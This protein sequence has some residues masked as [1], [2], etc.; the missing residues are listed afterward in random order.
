VA[1]SCI[2]K[3]VAA[4]WHVLA[5]KPVVEKPA[6]D[7]YVPKVDF[8]PLDVARAILQTLTNLPSAR[9]WLLRAASVR[10]A[11][12]EDVPKEDLD[13]YLNQLSAAESSIEELCSNFAVVDKQFEACLFLEL[14]TC[15]HRLGY[16]A[17]A[18]ELLKRARESIGLNFWLDG[19]MGKR[20]KFQIDPK[21]QLVLNVDGGIKEVRKIF[22]WKTSRYRC[23]YPL[24]PLFVLKRTMKFQIVKW[25]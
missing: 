20:T 6:G 5:E 16:V 14:A 7:L 11:V 9:W 10:L 18:R 15:F 13:C 2:H 8:E 1:A 23:Q 19:R 24:A 3:F 4:Q 12:A 25:W 17:R 21:A 22:F